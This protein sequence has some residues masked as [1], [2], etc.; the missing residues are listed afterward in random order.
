MK[1]LLNVAY[2]FLCLA[3]MLSINV[4]A[5]IDASV[6]TMIVQVVAAVAVTV[7]AVVTVLWRRA[8]KKVQKVLNIDENAKKEVE[9]EV[10]FD[11]DDDE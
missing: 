8:K 1:K 4:H 5:Y 10:Q 2:L 3:V 11:E 7:G 6:T 9:A